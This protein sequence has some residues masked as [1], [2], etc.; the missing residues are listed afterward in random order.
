[1]S[2][3]SLTTALNVL[4]VVLGALLAVATNYATD[5]DP[6]G[7]LRYLR[8][9]SLPLVLSALVL[10]VGVQVMLSFTQQ[11]RRARPEWNSRRL[12]YPGLEAHTEKDAAVFFGRDVEIGEILELLHPV[13]PSRRRFLTVM[14]PSG[15]GKTSLLQAGVVPALSER[16]GKWIVLPP[17]VPDVDPVGAL[18]AGFL[19]ALGD[20]PP[21]RRFLRRRS[22]E[23]AAAGRDFALTDGLAPA[24]A[25]L[26]TA[27]RRRGCSVLIIIDQLEEFHTVCPPE[28][29]DAFAALLRS[30][31]AADHRLWII[32]GVRSD[33]LTELMSGPFGPLMHQP[34]LVTPLERADLFAI[35]ERPAERAGISFTPDL[36]NHMVEDVATGDALPLLAYTLREL[37]VLAGAHRE[38]TEH[39]YREIKGVSGALSNRADR[40]RRALLAEDP[41]M[42]VLETLLRFVTLDRDTPS[43]RRLKRSDLG[44]RE[45][46][47]VE[48]FVAGRLLTAGV[49]GEVPI[50]D[51]AHEALL[52][53]WAPLRRAVEATADRLREMARLERLAA[54]WRRFGR[55]PTYLMSG[56]RLR[57]AE[58][59][60]RELPPSFLDPQVEE[61]LDASGRA[62]LATQERRSEA[63]ARQALQQLDQHPE[64][65]ALLALAAIEECA[66]TRMAYHALLG[67]AAACRARRLLAGHDDW[68]RAV[69]WSPDGRLMATASSDGTARIWDATG[70]EP[71]V[72]CR[73]HEAEV[74]SISWTPDSRRIATG[75]RDCTVRVW[76]AATGMPTEVLQGHTAE[77]QCVAWSPD[78][79]LLA[80]AASDHTARLW[81]LAGDAAVLTGHTREVRSVAWHPDGQLLATASRDHTVRLWQTKDGAP[82]GIFAQLEREVDA[83][84]WSPD[85]EKL[86]T[87]SRDR[88]ARVWSAGDGRLLAVMRGHTDSVRGVA[89]SNDSARLA[90]ASYDASC[91]IWDARTGEE[92]AT[93]RGHRG[94]IFT[95]A[96]SPDDRYVA[97]ASQDGYARVW[98][99][100]HGDELAVWSGHTADVKAVRWAPGG[101]RIASSSRDLT[102]RIWRVVD[103]AELHCLRGHDED[104]RGLAWRP[105]DSMIATA[106]YDGTI[107]LWDSDTGETRGLLVGH[108]RWIFAVA[109]SPDGRRLV[110]GSQD[111]SVR[112]WTLPTTDEEDAPEPL[113]LLGHEDD[114]RSTAWSHDGALVA[115]GGRDRTAR[116]W[117]ADGRLVRVLDGHDGEVN[118]VAWAPAA[119]WLATA[120]QDRTVRIWDPESA[121]PVAV[122]RGHESDVRCVDWSPAGDRLATGSQ[123]RTARIWHGLH[124]IELA[125]LH[126]HRDW[127]ESIAWSPDGTR[128]VTASRDRTVRIWDASADL[129]S[130]VTRARA[131]VF[132]QLTEQERSAAMLPRQSPVP[133]QSPRPDEGARPAG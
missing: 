127:V 56:E 33:F 1:M 64:T 118:A 100:T 55:L 110:S 66:P 61:F 63:L 35:I 4:F 107:R 60:A 122:L 77:V 46:R 47:V 82:L 32:G 18:E 131:R 8:T 125:I 31:L 23:S 73:G 104:V 34:V 126:G 76:D 114:V 116:I 54:D 6:E 113:V 53:W 94:W 119:R 71:L 65:A 42:P 108:Q 16:H 17:V 22:A 83:V 57:L 91:V 3:R 120:S 99:P 105:D 21:R 51:V 12:P 69:A 101:T 103:G 79:R 75:S 9:W 5:S 49:D 109:W 92:T 70:G 7:P 14:G 95:V 25:M 28:R 59:W 24:V 133:R 88:C 81:D 111:G 89:W 128:V 72:V 10:L 86:A 36:V 130:A 98:D 80:S 44:A 96:W 121:D 129:D 30:A 124:H 40:I 29:R 39:H 58:H 106:S 102:T 67:A 38:I 68:V 15:V 43:R 123:D 26:R 74:Q 52:R 37:V 41:S 48:A 62:D 20:P 97:T 13:V 87:G 85:G 50:V 90:T 115:S 27:L 45:L 112:I 19:A 117:T 2:R 78:G 93:L 11:P 84:A 132:R